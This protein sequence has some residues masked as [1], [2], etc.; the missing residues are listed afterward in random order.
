MKR[1][2][3]GSRRRRDEGVSQQIYAANGGTPP[4][5]VAVCPFFVVGGVGIEPTK[6]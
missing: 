4:E 5:A 2:W 1:R 3:A 6:A